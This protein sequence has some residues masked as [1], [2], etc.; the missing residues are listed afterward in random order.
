MV[1]TKFSRPITVWVAD[2]IP[3]RNLSILADFHGW[4][5]LHMFLSRCGHPDE[6]EYNGVHIKRYSI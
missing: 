2:G 1:K 5:G 6:F 4:G 3:Y